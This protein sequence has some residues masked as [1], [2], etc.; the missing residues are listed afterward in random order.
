MY[1]HS[2]TRLTSLWGDPS[3]LGRRTHAITSTMARAIKRLEDFGYQ[4]DEIKAYLYIED[5]DLEVARREWEEI[6]NGK[7]A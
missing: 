5:Y 7:T 2:V 6:F 4:D 3:R 1:S